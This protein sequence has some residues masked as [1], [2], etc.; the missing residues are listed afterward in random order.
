MDVR[1]SMLDMRKKCKTNTGVANVVAGIEEEEDS[2]ILEQCRK[3]M[4]DLA[5]LSAIMVATPI[6]PVTSSPFFHSCELTCSCPFKEHMCS[7]GSSSGVKKPSLSELA[8]SLQVLLVE[9]SM[10]GLGLE[11]GISKGKIKDL[12][13]HLVVAE[14]KEEKLSME[15]P[16]ERAEKES[17]D[18]AMNK[19]VKEHKA[20]VCKMAKE[21]ETVMVSLEQK[22]AEALEGV[23]KESLQNFNNFLADLKVN[24][25][26]HVQVSG[27]LFDAG[28]VDF[29]A[30]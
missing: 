10:T 15:V 24:I 11:E 2:A 14:G 6:S 4:I 22:H 12:S 29:D 8:L 18:A 5:G 7:A 28:K 19:M 13:E 27:G 26:L 30:L 23:K 16:A 20:L 21:Q 3:K 1:A 9:T 17:I 25:L